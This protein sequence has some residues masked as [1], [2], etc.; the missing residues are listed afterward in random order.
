MFGLGTSELVIIAIVAVVFFF[1]GEKMSEIARGLGKFT[2]EFKKGKAE[3]EE[4]INKVQ[5]DLKS[6]GEPQ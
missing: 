1:G 5:K 3:M 4:E 6:D 2:G